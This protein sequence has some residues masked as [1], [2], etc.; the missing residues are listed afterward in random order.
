MIEIA[1]GIGIDG[2][3][4]EIERG[5]GDILTEIGTSTEGR[6]IPAVVVEVETT[7]MVT[8][9][10][11]GITAGTAHALETTGILDGTFSLT[12]PRR[13]M[14]STVVDRPLPPEDQ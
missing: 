1:S 13:G 7:I 12:T 5:T 4:I 3:V 14:M 2:T 11:G 9:P 8:C 6:V 10:L